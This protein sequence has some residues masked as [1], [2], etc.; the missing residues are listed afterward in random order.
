MRKLVSF[1]TVASLMAL[2]VP[3]LAWAQEAPAAPA[4]ECGEFDGYRNFYGKVDRI[5][6]KELILDNRQGDKLK[7]QPAKE[8]EVVGTKTDW[9]RVKK[10]DWAIAAWKMSDNPRVAYKLCVKPEQTEAG[11]FEE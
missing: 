7:F 10:N 9:D 11:E 5:S 2:V 6:K 1:V 8:V 4:A 3:A